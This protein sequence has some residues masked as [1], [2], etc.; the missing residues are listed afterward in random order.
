MNSSPRPLASTAP[1]PPLPLGMDKADLD[2]LR[3]LV[4][5]Q[6]R[7]VYRLAR[8]LRR[9]SSAL[10]SLFGYSGGVLDALLC[11]VDEADVDRMLSRYR[12][13]KRA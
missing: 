13:T 9:D 4:Q 3:S 10:L 12:A 1:T 5:N 2:L 11:T 8:F 6:P 7:S